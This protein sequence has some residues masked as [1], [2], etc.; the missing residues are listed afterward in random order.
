MSAF[1]WLPSF[2]EARNED[3]HAQWREFWQQA[4]RSLVT[5]LGEDI[6]ADEEV[7]GTPYP[8]DRWIINGVARTI[9]ELDS[10]DERGA[11]W[12]PILAFGN[13]AA[14]WVEDFLRSWF[15]ARLTVTERDD[16]FVSE[17][18]AML[19]YVKE[20]PRWQVRRFH[21]TELRWILMGL[22]YLT[23]RVWRDEDAP[24]IES[25]H[26]EYTEW[27][28]DYVR[29]PEAAEHLV[30]FLKKPVARSLL[31]DGLEWL[32]EAAIEADDR[33]WRRR[34]DLPR[35]LAELLDYALRTDATVLTREPTARAFRELLRRLVDLQVPLALALADRIVGR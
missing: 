30:E 7:E 14:Y 3:E 21:V 18:R 11:L 32:R 23:Q 27:A 26:H 20:A 35:H 34:D 2:A 28:H 17:W 10:A 4:L 22:D 12:E 6:G 24:L 5:R 25:M 16:V 33:Y 9:L 19:G 29:D 15:E 8:S 1:G 13:A 31:D